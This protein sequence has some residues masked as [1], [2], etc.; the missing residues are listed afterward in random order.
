MKKIFALFFAFIFIEGF[1]SL[2]Q[3]TPQRIISLSPLITE[4]IYMLGAQDKL[5]GNT[6]YCERPAEA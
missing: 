6:V 1:L 2:A 4:E 3:N 5:V